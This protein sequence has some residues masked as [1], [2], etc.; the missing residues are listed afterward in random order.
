MTGSI[1]YEMAMCALGV[2][3]LMVSSAPSIWDIAA[4]TCIV[5]ESGGLV[6]EG[7]SRR[8]RFRFFEDFKWN[9]LTTFS[10]SNLPFENLS[11]FDVR[12]WRNPLIA[13]SPK[14]VKFTA[15]NLGKR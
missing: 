10:T 2:S 12:K 9:A 14:A 15:S 8:K 5:I 6:M 7:I 4:G 3:Q 11:T 13:G 1:S